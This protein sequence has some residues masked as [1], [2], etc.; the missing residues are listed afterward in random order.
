M[1]NICVYCNPNYSNEDRINTIKRKIDLVS[2]LIVL[3]KSIK[4]NWT[5]FDYDFYCFYNKNIKWSDRDKNR[6]SVFKDLNLIPVD[7]P[8]H[9]SVPWQTRIPCFIHP[10][11]RKGTHRLVLDCDMI[12]LKNPNFNLEVD[13]QCGFGGNVINHQYTDYMVN[14]YNFN[15][16]DILNK[17]YQKYR[18]FHTYIKDPS[19]WKKLYPYFNVGA[20]LI[21]EE[22]TQKLISFW[23]PT[24][25]LVLKDSWPLYLRDNLGNIP[26]QVMHISIQYTLSYSLLATSRNWQPFE[27]GINYLLKC[28]D[29]NKFGRKNI[30]L[31]HYC[32]V[33]AEEIAKREFNVYFNL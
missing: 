4:Q 9:P 20:V 3:Y 29:I 16:N 1:I 25:E 14:K 26:Y 7:K 6:V 17:N 22:L 27:R 33:G 23:R 30:A 24:Y 11:K 21:K 19:V 8:D 31:L 2:Q 13:W 32:G 28:Y 5:N 10:L 15:I 18:L 12:A